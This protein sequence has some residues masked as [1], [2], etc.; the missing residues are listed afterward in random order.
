MG[1]ATSAYEELFQD[2]DFGNLAEINERVNSYEIANKNQNVI[3]GITI[4]KLGYTKYKNGK[5]GDSTILSPV[6]LRKS[7]AEI[8]LETKN[9]NYKNKI[10][11][12][13]IE[14]GIRNKQNEL[15]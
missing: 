7:Q 3:S 4:S 10:E 12:N 1:D 8:A 11:R 14:N 13:E 15:S 6:Y 5:S 9:C 2:L